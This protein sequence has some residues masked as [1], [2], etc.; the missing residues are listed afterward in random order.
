MQGDLPFGGDAVEA[1]YFNWLKIPFLTVVRGGYDGYIRLRWDGTFSSPYDGFW[2]TWKNEEVEGWSEKIEQYL[3]MRFSHRDKYTAYYVGN[4]RE[5]VREIKIRA[6]GRKIIVAFPNVMWDG[7][8]YTAYKFTSPWDWLVKLVKFAK[9]NRDVFLVIRSHPHEALYYARARTYELL[10]TYVDDVDNIWLLPPEIKL[11]S[12]ELIDMLDGA[13]FAVFNGTIGMEIPIITG[14]KTAL[15][16]YSHYSHKGFTYDAKSWEDYVG[17]LMGK[18]EPV[19]EDPRR[20]A[21]YYFIYSLLP[22]EMAINQ[23]ETE[24]YLLSPC[25]FR[26]T[27]ENGKWTKYSEKLVELVG[28]KFNKESL[29]L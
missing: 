15:A 26:E 17:Y 23:R 28:F 4:T 7:S 14:K 1:M 16:G 8:V 13:S 25:S 9:Y 29:I 22:L 5:V 12:Y 3:S 21:Y 10:R 11:S 6:R 24:N 19:Q 27:Q 18:E 20:Y 2:N